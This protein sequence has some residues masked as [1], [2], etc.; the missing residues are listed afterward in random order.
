MKKINNQ[1][2]IRNTF[3]WYSIFSRQSVVCL[4]V[5]FIGLNC[6]AS[7][8][9]N[10]Q[11]CEAL[12]RAIEQTNYFKLKADTGCVH[13]QTNR[14]FSNSIIPD[15]SAETLF[16][17]DTVIV[18][19]QVDL[20]YNDANILIM[21]QEHM[22][23]IETYWKA[24]KQLIGHKPKFQLQISHGSLSV[25]R[26]EYT[27]IPDELDYMSLLYFYLELWRMPIPEY[28]IAGLKRPRF[29]YDYEI[30]AFRIIRKSDG[31]FTTDRYSVS[32]NP[33]IKDAA[34]MTISEKEELIEFFKKLF[35]PDPI[36][37]YILSVIDRQP[38]DSTES[39]DS[40]VHISNQVEN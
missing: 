7:A 21:G 13:H 38:I 33:K 3:E 19:S 20:I 39:A 35:S 12:T 5:F 40:T 18:I 27:P 32:T 30:N 37:K 29:D 22:Y 34:K 31:K 10:L 25:K 4:L 28:I 14:L 24:K 23:T 26:L 36:P 6:S 15:K 17:G 1:S 16:S 2:N 8:N 9:N 11:W